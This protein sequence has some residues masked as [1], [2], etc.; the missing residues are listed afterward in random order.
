MLF[1]RKDIALFFD[2]I[3]TIFN[4]STG[5]IISAED[6]KI[7]VITDEELLTQL[8]PLLDTE[9]PHTLEAI[10]VAEQYYQGKYPKR[11]LKDWA[12]LISQLKSE[13]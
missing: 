8:K 12:A 5:S 2:K 6:E 11:R 10:K 7:T 1:K 13:L 9:T 4:N 3:E